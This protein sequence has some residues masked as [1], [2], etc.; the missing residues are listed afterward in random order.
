MS[1]YRARKTTV[2]GV[3]FDSMG[4]ARRYQELRLLERAGEISDLC[5]QVPYAL[6][7]NGVHVCD[8]VADFT[9]VV[10]W[11]GVK[12][13][14]DF[15]GFRTAEYRLK[16]KLMRACHGIEILETGAAPKPRRK[17]ARRPLAKQE[18]A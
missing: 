8:Y 17:P 18:A 12:A 10:R 11:S 9:Y 14:E 1:K 16:R 5:R 6:N 13:V 15:K 4:E 2:D 7:V 3:T